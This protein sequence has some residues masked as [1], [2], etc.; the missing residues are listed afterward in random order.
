MAGS[1]LGKSYGERAFDG[2]ARMTHD[3]PYVATWRPAAPP[4]G[5]ASSCGNCGGTP[6]FS[7]E[8]RSPAASTVGSRRAREITDAAADLHRGAWGRAAWPLVAR[9]Q[10]PAMPVI[11]GTPERATDD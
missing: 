1:A 2:V 3:R 8:A 10:Q 7:A 4:E 9:A 6:T 11:G 5:I